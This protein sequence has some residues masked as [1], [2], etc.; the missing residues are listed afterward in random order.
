MHGSPAAS[1]RSRT[2]NPLSLIDGQHAVALQPRELLLNIERRP[3]RQSGRQLAHELD[4]TVERNRVD[5]ELHC[6]GEAVTAVVLREVVEQADANRRGT[7]GSS[8]NNGTAAASDTGSNFTRTRA[9]ISTASG[10]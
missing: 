3:T 4:G 5:A 1:A 9:P 10:D 7:H 6:C 2:I 8:S